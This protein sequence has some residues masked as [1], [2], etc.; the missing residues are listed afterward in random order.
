MY[1]SDTDHTPFDVGAYASSTTYISGMSVKKSADEVKEQIQER[2]AEMLGVSDHKSID[3]RK[4]R[5]WALD[6]IR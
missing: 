4:R 1:S 6:G 2:A 3:L 5:A